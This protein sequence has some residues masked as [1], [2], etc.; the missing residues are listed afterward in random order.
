M[1]I[2]FR[3]ALSL[4]PVFCIQEHITY[5]CNGI[6]IRSSRVPRKC[7]VQVNVVQQLYFVRATRILASAKKSNEHS[8]QT[9]LQ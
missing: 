2:R 3:P 8:Y 6:S 4:P 7:I 1:P 5:S 9:H